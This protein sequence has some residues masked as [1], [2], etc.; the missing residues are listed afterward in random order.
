M[1]VKNHLKRYIPEQMVYKL[2]MGIEIVS[3]SRLIRNIESSSIN[4]DYIIGTP[5]HSNLGDHLITLAQFDFIRMTKC[6]R[7]IVE[8]PSEMFQLFKYRLKNAI[9]RDSRIFINGGGW[10]GNLWV[11]EEL[12]MQE[13]I[14]MFAD[15]QIVVFPQTIYFDEY[16]RPYNELIESANRIYSK[17]ENLTL[18][19]RDRQ[20]YD[21]AKMIYPSLDVL[22]VPDIALSFFDKA[23]KNSNYLNMKVGY[24]LRN[25]REL[26]RGNE[27][28][29]V[30]WQLLKQRGFSRKELST[31]THFR[32]PTF[33][34]EF[35]VLRRLRQF[36]DCSIVV[37]DRLHGM[38]FA[39]ITDTPCIVFD[40]K[41][42]KI[43]GVYGEW[44]KDSK[45]ILT[46]FEHR[47]V[48]EII[49]FLE[50]LGSHKT[51][52]SPIE[53]EFRKLRELINI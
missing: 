29:L 9:D 52:N 3:F 7:K 48:S 1:N 24:C 47:D 50:N 27:S 51:R 36:A 40:N 45:S 19:V 39:Y 22:L 53:A 49:H 11:N 2:K 18:C 44:L 4:Q 8:I 14:E 5:I 21:L 20:S 33:F 35:I 10:M 38:I 12:L 6:K 41:T 25:D 15:H 42:H 16:T 30:L 37:T 17:C 43:S 23:P 32:I 13:I 28:E 31:I 26:S 34:R 46:L